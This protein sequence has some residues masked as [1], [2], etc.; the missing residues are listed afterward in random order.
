MSEVVY[1]CVS[2]KPIPPSRVEALRSMDVPEELMTVKEHSLARKKQGVYFGEQGSGQLVLVDKVYDD[3][4]RS[5]FSSS[6]AE[7]DSDS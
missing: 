4:V 3:S 7:E 2:G 6:E 5:V 1:C